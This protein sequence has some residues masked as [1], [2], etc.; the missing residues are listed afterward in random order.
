M[1]F[2]N[3]LQKKVILNRISSDSSSKRRRNCY[4]IDEEQMNVKKLKG[5]QIF[6][7][8]YTLDV[9]F[10]ESHKIRNGFYWMMLVR[11]LAI[12]QTRAGGFK[13]KSLRK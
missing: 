3:L 4:R 10:I 9:Y 13:R 6:M 1:S 12:G 2:I 11:F 7:I 5:D 8:F